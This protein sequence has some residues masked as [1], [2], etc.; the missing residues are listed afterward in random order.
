[1]EIIFKAWAVILLSIIS[2]IF[3]HIAGKGGFSNAKLI[4]RIGCPFVFLIALWALKGF[5]FAFWWV[6]LLV[7]GLNA[8]VM[9]TY[10]DYLAPDGSSENWLCWLITG[11][12]Y[13]LSAF[14]LIICG[15][16]WY[17][18]VIRS[19]VLAI[20]IMTVSEKLSIA[21]Q[22]EGMRGFLYNITIPILLI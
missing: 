19:I 20:L 8:G 9:S 14:P 4:R 18:V 22:E 5:N 3:Y 7:F 17:S 1:M 16:H 11:F 12:G 10:H 6:Y 15:I 2:G 21:W 13:G